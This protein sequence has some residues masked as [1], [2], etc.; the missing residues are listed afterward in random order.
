VTVCG[1]PNRVSLSRT[2]ACGPHN[3]CQNVV[4]TW[5]AGTALTVCGNP[6]RVS[7]SRTAC[8]RRPTLIVRQISNLTKHLGDTRNSETIFKYGPRNTVSKRSN[9]PEI[10]ITTYYSC[11]SYG[12]MIE[13]R[14]TKRSFPMS[15]EHT[16]RTASHNPLSPLYLSLPHHLFPRPIECLL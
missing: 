15:E 11:L 16:N 4:I 10:S 3:M 2:V 5:L 1:N 6:N 7:F 8:L 9:S 14:T 12:L 13:V